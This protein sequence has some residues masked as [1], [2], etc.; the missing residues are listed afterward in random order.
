MAKKNPPKIADISIFGHFRAPYGHHSGM[1]T[2]Y[3]CRGGSELQFK[4]CYI[5]IGQELA[6]EM[7]KM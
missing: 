7:R 4:G 2:T 5:K 6:S 1:I 3:S